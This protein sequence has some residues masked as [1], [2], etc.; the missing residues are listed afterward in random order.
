MVRFAIGSKTAGSIAYPSARC[1]VTALRPAFGA[2]GRTGVLS[3]SESLDKLGPLCTSA[4]DCAIVLDVIRCKD[5]DD[6]SSRKIFL[7]DS[8]SVDITKLTIGYIEDAEME[9]VDVLRSKGVIMV[10]FK[11]NYTIESVQGILNFTMDVD[12]LAHFDTWQRSGQDDEFEAQDQWPT[13]LRWARVIP[14]V[15]YIQSQRA[16]GKLTQEVKEGF[17][18]HAFMEM[19]LIGKRF[20]SADKNQVLLLIKKTTGQF[21]Q[22]R[23]AKHSAIL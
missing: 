17:T 4:V 8:F 7:D 11:L 21:V 22:R 9:V 18:V 6:L 20:V 13:E 10:P 23:N 14:A 16:R 12:M 3:L 19:L 1:G 5:P 2:V 15:D